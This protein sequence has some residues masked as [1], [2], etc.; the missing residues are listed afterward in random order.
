MMIKEI[1]AG[2]IAIDLHIQI[3]ICWDKAIVRYIE[4]YVEAHVWSDRGIKKD[5]KGQNEGIDHKLQPCSH[6][7]NC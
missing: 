4:R 1:I 7:S 6:R 5:G 3:P 2:Y